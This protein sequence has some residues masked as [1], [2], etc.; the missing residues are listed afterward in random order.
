[1]N[2]Y[3]IQFPETPYLINIPV[4]SLVDHFTVWHNTS[5]SHSYTVDIYNEYLY[6]LKYEIIIK[7]SINNC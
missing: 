1:M 6:Q 3:P 2:V 4:V 7:L 5:K